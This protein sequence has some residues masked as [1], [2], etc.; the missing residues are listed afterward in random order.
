LAHSPEKT[1]LQTLEA[2]SEPPPVPAVE[3]GPCT[4]AVIFVIFVNR[5][6]VAPYCNCQS[7]EGIVRVLHGPAKDKTALFFRYLSH[8]L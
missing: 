8:D 5:V 3:A 1:I 2:V 6:C 4:F 7:G